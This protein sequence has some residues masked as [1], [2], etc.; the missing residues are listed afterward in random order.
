M[1]L[2]IWTVVPNA[3]K[4]ITAFGNDYVVFGGEFTSVWVVQCSTKSSKRTEIY[5]MK[6]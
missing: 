5:L 2:G 3:V 1:D 6:I 4:Y